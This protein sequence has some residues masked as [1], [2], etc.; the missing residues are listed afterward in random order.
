MLPERVPIL[1]IEDNLADL[2]LAAEL[3]EDEAP[4]RFRIEPVRRLAEGLEALQAERFAFVILD[5]S[6]PDANGVA[7]IDAI[8]AAAPSA[9]VIVL[10]GLLDDGTRCAAAGCGA[11]ACFVKGEESVGP[12]V[13]LMESILEQRA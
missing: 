7:A 8:R 6:L 5:L 10:S 3:I 2:R 1:L 11:A 4:G 9:P 13:D 12:L